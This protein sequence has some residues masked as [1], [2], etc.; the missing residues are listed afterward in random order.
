MVTMLDVLLLLHQA[1]SDVSSVRLSS[2]AKP[3]SK[4]N[5][6]LHPPGQRLPAG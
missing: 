1:T 3:A 5:T 4:K 2:A 6:N